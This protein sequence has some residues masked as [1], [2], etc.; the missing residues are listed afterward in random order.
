MVVL[1]LAFVA[2]VV[3]VVV[4]VEPVPLFTIATAA[5][6]PIMRYPNNKIIA[7]TKQQSSFEQILS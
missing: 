1:E 6:F 5:I 2:V 3:V 7:I 4:V